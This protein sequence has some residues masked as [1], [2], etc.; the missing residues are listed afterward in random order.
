[1]VAIGS[2]F[3]DVLYCSLFTDT[4]EHELIQEIINDKRRIKD[5]GQ[6]SPHGQTSSLESFHSV[7]NHYAPKMFHFSFEG[8]E[9]R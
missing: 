5:I 6:L 8:M 4:P 9:S 7:I 2:Y 1:M 3:A